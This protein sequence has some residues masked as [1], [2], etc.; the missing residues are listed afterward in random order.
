MKK[1]TWV[2]IISV[3]A[4]L[5][6]GYYA[7]RSFSKGDSGIQLK[8]AKIEKG[9]LT[10]SVTATGTVNALF[11]VLVGT[12]VSGT[13]SKIYV[14]YNS[15]VKEGQIIAEID[16]TYLLASVEDAKATLDRTRIQMEQFKRVYDRNK[17]LFDE[18]VLSQ[19]E[20][21]QSLAD[22]ETS[23]TTYHSAEAQ[24]NRALINLRYATIKAPISGVVISRSVDVGQTV[25]A[26][27]STPTLFTIANDLTQMQVQASVDEADIGQVKVGQEVRF[28]V[29]AY[30][31]TYFK[32]KVNQIRLL[33]TNVSNVVT[34]TVIIDVS[35]PDLK[36]LPGMTANIN[37]IIEEKVD[38]FSVPLNA[39]KFTPGE[40]L[41]KRYHISLPDSLKG[42]KEK[43]GANKSE[44]SGPLPK[45]GQAKVIWIKNADTI[46]AV[47]IVVGIN[48]GSSIEVKGEFE[49][50]DE[51]VTGVIQ[52]QQQ[53]TS[54]NPFVPQMGGGR[55]TGSGGGGGGGG[56]RR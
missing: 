51:V 17:K 9:K 30:P 25:A 38:V 54:Q 31:G 36:I 14:D 28:T 53:A 8:T 6:G 20:Y 49:E 48:D 32:G 3:L 7:F 11:T 35:N 15:H 34:Y 16:K 10:V 18:K 39:L 4:L 37:I 56:S 33:A 2:I 22:Y 13:I 26:S 12:Q 24:Y 46:R 52:T 23:V 27:F 19:M 29:D 43:R 42:N 41:I 45:E 5:G 1:K 50:G 47:N 44:F 40:G 55:G 21:D